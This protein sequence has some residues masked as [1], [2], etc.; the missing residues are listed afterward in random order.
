MQDLD[1]A[2]VDIGAIR[3]QLARGA[4]FRGYGPATVSATG[5]LAL[6]AAAAQAL[7]LPRPAADVAAFL[8]L[9]VGV[10]A[11]SA[12]VIGVETVTRSRRLHSG[13]ADAMIHAAIEQLIPAGAAGALATVVIVQASP[14]AVWLLPG[15]WQIL[16]GLGIF[17]SSRALPRQV[18][19]AG[20]WY[21][22]AG[23]ACLAFAKGDAALSPWA[24]GVP[25]GLGQLLTAALL[26]R[27]IG[28][29]D[30]RG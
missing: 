25:F 14:E 16:F 30:A 22:A 7:W 6:A 9:W 8:A 5:V 3:S 19:G 18:F 15:L 2:L 29:L 23:L 13:L 28:E 10:A 12:L 24:M 1:R 27:G 21:L 4:V 17:A 26:H 11:L 20:V